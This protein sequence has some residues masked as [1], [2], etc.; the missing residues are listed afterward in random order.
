MFF[1]IIFFI[2]LILNIKDTDI[3]K[4]L[5]E[6]TILITDFSSLHTDFAFMNKKIIYYQYDEKDYKEKHIDKGILH[7]C[8]ENDVFGLL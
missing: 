6:G 2:I 8:F 5:I 4:L 3:Q 1:F 7:F